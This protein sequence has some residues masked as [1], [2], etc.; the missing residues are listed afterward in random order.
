MEF[1]EM[2]VEELQMRMAEIGNAMKNEDS[3]IDALTVEA[4]AINEELDA[5]AAE[6]AKK[7]ELRQMVAKMDLPIIDEVPN[8]EERGS[9]KMEL[10]ELRASKEYAEAFLNGWRSGDKKMTECR[11][12]LTTNTTGQGLTGYVPVPTE[13][14]TEIQTA[15]EEREL[16]RHISRSAFK[17]NVKIGFE[18]SAT[19]ASIHV[20]GTN[21]PTEEVV[22]LGAVEIKAETIKK[23]IR[24]SDEALNGTTV[25]TIGYLYREIAYRIAEKA[26]EVVIGKIT[27]AP[28]AATATA[29][30][31]PQTTAS[32]LALDTILMA[33]VPLVGTGTE[34]LVM[35]RGTYAA[36]RS[37]ELTANYAGADAFDGMRDRIIFTDKLAAF[38][39]ASANDVVIIRGDLSAVRGNFPNGNDVEILVDPYTD[40]E[41]DLVK[42]VGKQYAG[43]G[44]IRDKHL[45]VVKKV[46]ANG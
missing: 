44:I 14:E 3:D 45:A 46:A 16:L 4:R 8:I 33:G 13:L 1:K 7:A 9:K 20:E 21:A 11:A 30:G 32:A 43:F 5:R 41:S 40:A 34:Y 2:S 31:V 15:W 42:I 39:A 25:D 27:G 10:K 29:V 35:N 19:G 38:S 18:L 12:L 36:L 26:E 24:V 28:A 23:W 22:T 17:G 37:L 6:E